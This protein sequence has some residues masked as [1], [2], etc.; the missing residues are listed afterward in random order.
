[1]PKFQKKRAK[2]GLV[3]QLYCLASILL[4]IGSNNGVEGTNLKV[5]T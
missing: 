4:I 3:K 2:I 5:E 1:M